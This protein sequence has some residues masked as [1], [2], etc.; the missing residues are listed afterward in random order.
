LERS[1][2]SSPQSIMAFL[3]M[4]L[5]F[6]TYKLNDIPATP[7]DT[8]KKARKIGREAGLEYVYEGNVPGE[9]QGNTHCPSCGKL[10]IKRFGFEIVEDQLKNGKCPDCGSEI[11]GVF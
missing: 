10:L 1:P 4:S 7:I 9:E 2:D 3:G 8:L 6:P 5:G 11:D